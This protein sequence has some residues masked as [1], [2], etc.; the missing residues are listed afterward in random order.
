VPP[1]DDLH[2]GHTIAKDA[3]I[4]DH[5]IA[6]ETST[7][8]QSLAASGHTASAQPRP[9]SRNLVPR[10]ASGA[11]RTTPSMA[12]PAPMTSTPFGEMPSREVSE[13]E[14]ALW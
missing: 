11:A 8:E 7:L 1:Q 13:A 12:A 10:Q 14:V 9:V 4:S 6:L 2:L 5:D 3:S